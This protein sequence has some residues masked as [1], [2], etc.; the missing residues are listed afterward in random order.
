LVV[1]GCATVQGPVVH[2]VVRRI[3]GLEAGLNKTKPAGGFKGSR[4]SQREGEETE[5][6]DNNGRFSRTED[7]EQPAVVKIPLSINVIEGGDEGG[8]AIKNCW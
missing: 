4:G 5:N 3:K 1:G 7:L 6:M 2:I 8:V